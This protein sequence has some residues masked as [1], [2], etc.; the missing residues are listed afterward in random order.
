MSNI[1][2]LAYA[3]A[4]GVLFAGII[5]YAVGRQPEPSAPAPV[6]AMAPTVQTVPVVDDFADVG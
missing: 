2:V 6:P 3:A 4:A 1:A 5:W